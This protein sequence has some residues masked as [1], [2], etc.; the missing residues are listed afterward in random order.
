MP[1]FPLSLRL[2]RNSAVTSDLLPAGASSLVEKG[3]WEDISHLIEERIGALADIESKKLLALIYGEA[4]L[5]NNNFDGAY[6]QFYLLKNNYQKEQIGHIASYLLSLL[7]ATNGDPYGANYEL[8]QLLDILK[9]TDPLFAY[10]NLL[11][12]ET[13]LAT[14]QF[15][16]M[17]SAVSRDDIAYPEELQL[18]R[19]LRQADLFY[20]SNQPVK[21]FVA[22]RLVE[23]EHVIDDQPYSLNGLCETLYN[24]RS[25]GEAALCYSNLAELT[26]SRDQL[27]MIYYRSTMAQLKLTDDPAK[28][29]NDFSRIEDAFPGT[30]A[31]FRA[32]VKKTDLRYISR[33]DWSS[34]AVKYYHALAEKSDYREVSAESYFK[35]A[36]LYHFT[37]DNSQ[38]I[39]LLNTLLRNI[40]TGP[41]RPSA[42]ALLIQLL[43]DELQRLV[44]DERYTDALTLA[45][46]HRDFLKQLA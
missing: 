28:H 1:E 37:G 38:A 4:L 35:E 5:R 15:D 42:Q 17:K 23:R 21:A 46:R 27:G 22:Y 2:K 13:C 34:T 14:G 40:R 32:A 18:Q 6:K 33:K 16:K 7:I 30:E 8:R 9:N 20:A 45:R 12:A 3:M 39:E 26:D 25:Y 31:G 19:E 44:D 36:L 24:Q 43:P 29:I 41:V 11:F 10:V